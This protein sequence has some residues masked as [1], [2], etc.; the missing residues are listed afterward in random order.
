MVDEYLSAMDELISGETWLSEETRAY[1]QNKLA[2]M[3]VEVG[4][5]D[6]WPDTSRLKVRSRAEGGTLFDE[7]RSVAAF[8]L[9]SERYLLDHPDEGAYWVDVLDVNAWY[10]LLT[11]TVRIG[12]G[13]LGGVYWPQGASYEER[14]A[15][16]GATVG[17]ELSHAFDNEG[18][19]FDV[20][21]SYRNWWTDQD[22]KHFEDRV[23]RLTDALSSIDPL[24]EGGY[25]GQAVCGE[26]IA[27]MAG[28]KASLMV[29]RN[30]PDF[31]YDAFFRA[32]AK[33]WLSL[34]EFDDAL[35]HYVNDVHP[36]DGTRVNVSLRECDEF[37]E[38]YAISEGDGMWLD[39]PD[40]VS[41]W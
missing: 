28:L 33:S 12:C 41:V 9:E 3:N 26:T 16:V 10:D 20:D 22:L 35:L 5:P 27:D 30:H 19:M 21:G 15:G 39:E 2:T 31:D 23:A 14:L 38:T 1:A 13:I 11:N 18:A 8:D 29:A 7:V 4:H 24:G 17:H 6:V 36:L 37:L 32:F 25:D 40:R 34:C